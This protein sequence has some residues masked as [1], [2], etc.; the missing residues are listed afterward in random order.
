MLS[1]ERRVTGRWSCGAGRTCCTDI[2]RADR[3][4]RAGGGRNVPRWRCFIHWD[5]ARCWRVVLLKGEEQGGQR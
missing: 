5:V 3:R 2:S 1:N 4:G